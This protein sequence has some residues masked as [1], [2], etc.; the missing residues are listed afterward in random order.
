MHRE[1]LIIL[2]FGLVEIL[3]RLVRPT[4][5]GRTLALFSILPSGL[6]AG[7]LLKVPLDAIQLGTELCLHAIEMR[8]QP[9]KSLP[10]GFS[11]FLKG[12]AEIGGFGLH[13]FEM[14]LLLP[15]APAEVNLRLL[16]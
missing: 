4:I 2:G 3:Q 9:K 5:R 14:F 7:T 15:R 11:D 10:C 12:P 1:V 16:G 8:A 6:G 13:F